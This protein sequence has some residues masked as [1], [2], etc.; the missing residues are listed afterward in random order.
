MRKGLPELVALVPFGACG[1]FV[2][3]GWAGHNPVGVEKTNRN[4]PKIGAGR[5]P[6]SRHGHHS[7]LGQIRY[8]PSLTHDPIKRRGSAERERDRVR[9]QRATG[10]DP[11]RAR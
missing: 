8:P 1:K 9:V 6:S 10:I 11:V 5:Q 3:R 2:G 4:L 7:R